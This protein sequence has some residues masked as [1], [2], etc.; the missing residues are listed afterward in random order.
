MLALVESGS[1]PPLSARR[2][3]AWVA[4]I[5]LE[6]QH[7]GRTERHQAVRDFVWQRQQG[8]LCRVHFDRML[9]LFGSCCGK[10]GVLL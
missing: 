4:P 9:G 1:E 7:N 5:S 10:R 8:F 6:H 3:A 2:L